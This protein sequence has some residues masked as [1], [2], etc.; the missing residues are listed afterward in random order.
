MAILIV[1]IEHGCKAPWRDRA[2][3]VDTHIRQDA[4][5]TF[6]LMHRQ[7]ETF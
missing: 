1:F 3:P 6:A 7:R 4:S 2:T 5:R